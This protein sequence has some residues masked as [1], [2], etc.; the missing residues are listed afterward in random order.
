MAMK[1]FAHV[2]THVTSQSVGTS[3]ASDPRS[4]LR[5][6]YNELECLT[7]ELD[8]Q[9]QELQNVTEQLHTAQLLV[10][11]ERQRKS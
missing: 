6:N 4:A 7:S 8:K 1:L 3:M 9:L 2:R 11:D 5:D 10:E